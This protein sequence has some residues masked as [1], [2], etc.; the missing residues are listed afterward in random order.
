MSDAT[1]WWIA[2]GVAV[3]LELATGTFY[4]LML[5]IGLAAAAV[6]AHLGAGFSMQLVAAAVI[7]GGAVTAL[8]LLRARQP[9][10]PPAGANRDVN[11]DIG[12]RVTVTQWNPDGT[13][14]V[15]YRGASWAARYAGTDAPAPGEHVI[16]AVDGSQ[17]LLGR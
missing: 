4:L 10:A 15:Q 11:I 16:R 7:G 13:T 12:E 2:T 9:A 14:R 1:L 3:A 6:A 8:H 17:L 5:A